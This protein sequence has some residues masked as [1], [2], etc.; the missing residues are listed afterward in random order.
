[1]KRREEEEDKTEEGN[2]KGKKASRMLILSNFGEIHWA[3]N[4]SKS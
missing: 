1:M 3:Y 4:L 2:E